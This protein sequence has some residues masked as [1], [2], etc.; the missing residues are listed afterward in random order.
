MLTSYGKDNKQL[1][2]LLRT[3]GAAS[4]ELRMT[5]SNH[6]QYIRGRPI[7]E[8]PATVEEYYWRQVFKNR[9]QQDPCDVTP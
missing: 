6:P 3:R 2:Q 7:R 8:Q 9:R 4:P 5:M 1:K